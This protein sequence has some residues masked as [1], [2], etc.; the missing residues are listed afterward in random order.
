[1]L[2]I[3]F[4]M[5]AT[6]YSEAKGLAQDIRHYVHLQNLLTSYN[7][8][9]LGRVGFALLLGFAQVLSLFASIQVRRWM[10][11]TLPIMSLALLLSALVSFSVFNRYKRDA[12]RLEE[13]RP[14]ED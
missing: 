14:N 1:M 10:A 2:A 11:A 7:V 4:S 8:W 3:G 12:I 5:L 13:L 6:G 9:T